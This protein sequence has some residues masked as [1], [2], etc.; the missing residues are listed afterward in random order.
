MKLYKFKR[1]LV[2]ASIV[3]SKKLIRPTRIT[4][5]NEN[6]TKKQKKKFRDEQV[7][8]EAGAASLLDFI[9]F[10]SYLQLHCGDVKPVKGEESIIEI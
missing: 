6:V 9:R 8:I 1:S 7:T 3:S 4:C 2:N 5:I 10:P